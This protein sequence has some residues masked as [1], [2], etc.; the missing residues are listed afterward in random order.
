MSSP[1]ESHWT[2]VKGMLW[3]AKGTLYYGI[4]IILTVASQTVMIKAFCD[5][6]W[7]ASRWSSI[8]LWS[9]N[10]SWY[11]FGFM[12]VSHKQQL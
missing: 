10:I 1:L 9:C 6:D 2:A 5:G 4:Q 11:Y 12:V 8:Y 3:Q 7:A